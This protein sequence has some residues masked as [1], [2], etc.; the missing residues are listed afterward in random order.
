MAGRS[1]RAL[2]Q[3]PHKRG[4]ADEPGRMKA[5]WNVYSSAPIAAS[6]AAPA[7]MQPQHDAANKRMCSEAA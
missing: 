5:T 4:D 3:P 1:Q 7:A 2:Y 6:K